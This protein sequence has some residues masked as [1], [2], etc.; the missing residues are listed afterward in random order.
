MILTL[1]DPKIQS[2][3]ESLRRR[4]P[5]NVAFSCSFLLD[6]SKKSIVKRTMSINHPDLF[7]GR[8][9]QASYGNG[10]KPRVGIVFKFC[11]L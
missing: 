5:I 11:I 2:R 4:V 10:A 9:A 1:D 3:D 8:T 6:R 7:G